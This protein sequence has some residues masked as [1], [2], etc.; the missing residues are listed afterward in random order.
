MS[1]TWTFFLASLLVLPL[2]ASC[3][4]T[5][6]YKR[7]SLEYV[8]VHETE[9]AFQVPITNRF[10]FPIETTYVKVSCS[11]SR[12]DRV[13]R[14]KLQPGETKMAT[15]DVSLNGRKSMLGI[16][17]DIYGWKQ[18]EPVPREQK[19]GDALHIGQYQ[20]E[21]PVA[22]RFE[23]SGFRKKLEVS[24]GK[25][26]TLIF[27]NRSGVSWSGVSV[28]SESEG[29]T[30][31]VTERLE[32]PLPHD[33][34][35]QVSVSGLSEEKLTALQLDFYQIMESGIHVKRFAGEVP[36]EFLRPYELRPRFFL[37]DVT[38]DDQY[39]TLNCRN[40]DARALVE[41][42]VVL[43]DGEEVSAGESFS[44]KSLSDNWIRLRFHPEGN[45]GNSGE[46]VIAL[47]AKNWSSSLQVRRNK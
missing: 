16:S 18:G 14:I 43:V 1:Q 28:V 26:A 12:P 8:S 5:L 3:A 19:L 21:I 47:P 9:I 2:S 32:R 22:P 23:L 27:H 6:D 41:N 29:A 17:I 38:S 4:Q 15:F 35:F 11:C 42:L 13:G 33:Q 31:D 34:P 25:P 24:P 37:G 7:F 30:F 39:V 44:K 20:V 45:W 46:I 36:L 40:G 10:D